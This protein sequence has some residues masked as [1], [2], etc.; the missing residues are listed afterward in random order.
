MSMCSLPVVYEK[1][2][3]TF[4]DKY[5]KNTTNQQQYGK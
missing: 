4:E 5:K 2:R 1:R 3:E